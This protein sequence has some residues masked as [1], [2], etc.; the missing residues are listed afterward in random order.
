MRVYVVRA[1][2]LQPQ[3]SNGL[4]ISS[5][6][7][8]VSL[9]SGTTEP[10][11]LPKLASRSWGSLRLILRRSLPRRLPL[12]TG[13]HFQSTPHPPQPTW[14]DSPFPVAFPSL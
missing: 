9:I 14:T 11:C 4:V 2:N 13:T 6:S 10:G 5:P 8:V 7:P 1:I 3:D 12:L